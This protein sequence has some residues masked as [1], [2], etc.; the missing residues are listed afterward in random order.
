MRGG[1]LRGTSSAWGLLSPGRRDSSY[2]DSFIKFARLWCSFLLRFQCILYFSYLKHVCQ[3]F[4]EWSVSCEANKI[5]LSFVLFFH[6]LVGY[7]NKKI[8]R[9]IYLLLL[10]I[11]SSVLGIYNYILSINRKEKRTLFKRDFFLWSAVFVKV[12][13][14]LIQKLTLILQSQKSTRRASAGHKL[15]TR[16]E[17]QKNAFLRN[18]TSI[19]M[20]TID[21]GKLSTSSSNAVAYLLF[22]RTLVTANEQN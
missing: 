22:F 1:E 12:W 6:P 15:H 18:G 8:P 10:V 17:R 19:I 9:L 7:D 20:L 16:P 4:T 3:A 21:S 5:F 11:F 13:S 2:S 14:L